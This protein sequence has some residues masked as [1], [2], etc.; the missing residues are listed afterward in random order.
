[1]ITIGAEA[2]LIVGRPALRAGICISC[3]LLPITV[4]NYQIVR[5]TR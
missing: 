5:T 3:N 4:G 1:M 2:I